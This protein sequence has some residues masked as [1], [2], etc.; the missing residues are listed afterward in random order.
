MKI[1]VRLFGKRNFAILM[2]PNLFGA[3]SKYTSLVRAKIANKIALF[4]LFCSA[5]ILLVFW[6]TGQFPKA[7][8]WFGLFVA[9]NLVSLIHMLGNGKYQPAKVSQN[10]TRKKTGRHSLSAT[11]VN[12][13]SWGLMAILLFPEADVARK[14]IITSVISGLMGGGIF[15][16][17][18]RPRI[19]FAYAFVLF[20]S[21]QLVLIRMG[22]GVYL[23]IL[24]LNTV[25]FVMLVASLR[26]LS[27][28]QAHRIELVTE[29]EKS[30]R[31]KQN[32]LQ[33]YSNHGS[34]WLWET[35]A[36]GYL[37][38]CDKKA[39]RVTG[40]KPWVLETL[41]VHQ[42]FTTDE[43]G[44]A[45]GKPENG[46]STSRIDLESQMRHHK[47]FKDIVVNLKNNGQEKRW[48]RISGHGHHDA[49]G[50]LSGYRGLC[51]DI[52]ESMQNEQKLVQLAHFDGI[53]GFHNR[54]HF[55]TE[56]GKIIMKMLEQNESFALMVMDFNKFRKINDTLGYPAGD[57]VLIEV[58][59]RIRSVLRESDYVARL[60]ADEFAIIMRGAG[61]KEIAAK[62]ADKLIKAFDRPVDA[63]GWM[64]NVKVSIGITLAPEHGWFRV[65]LL[66]NATLAHYR[67][68]QETT[69]SYHFFSPKMD[70]Q[71]RQRLELEMELRDAIRQDQL[72]LYYQPIVDAKTGEICSYEALIRWNHPKRGMIS[73]AVF[74][75]IAEDS[76]MIVDIG[77]MVL[78]QAC[79]EASKWE[80]DRRVAVNLSAQQ[81]LNANLDEVIASALKESGLPAHRLEVEL[82]ESVLIENADD[83]LAL[84]H[85]LRSMGVRIALD[86][87]GTG[88]SSLLYLVN[89]HFDK[90]KIDQSFVK[91]AE[92][93]NDQMEVVHAVIRLAKNLGMRTTAEG[94]ETLDK[95]TMLRNEGCDEIQ[96]YLISKPVP[97]EELG[98]LDHE[99]VSLGISPAEKEDK[100]VNAA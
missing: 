81:F 1:M 76:G 2:N 4:N 8:F 87:F 42:L 7:L 98:R 45:E 84:L 56:I 12:G 68:K 90:I 24:V 86:D 10:A 48:F 53:T 40:L 29:L 36:E 32:L 26:M 54:G 20:V 64:V 5:Y 22:G 59:R 77:E 80:N 39:E 67:A 34:E 61:S 69:N 92:Q 3:S 37:I 85:K 99:I 55:T 33:E 65:D 82:T 27:N 35:N 52:T 60:G 44:Y 17:S 100:R 78:Y 51:Q 9:L 50:E 73:P 96:G 6:P 31:S 18:Y 97:A 63:I 16:L 94:V 30:N 88:Y 25:Y 21:S 11:V 13:F 70:L 14:V 75:P 15:L 57:A 74:I 79:H 58:S 95:F 47:S 91:R 49:N 71:I 23:S 66:N 19:A 93:R 72:V 43:P 89:F 38:N 46:A 62:Y 41:R 83:T 28:V